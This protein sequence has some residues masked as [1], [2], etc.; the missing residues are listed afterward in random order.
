[1][2]AKLRR[3]FLTGATGHLGHRVVKLAREWDFIYCWHYKPPDKSIFGTPVHLNL[4]N[5]RDVHEALTHYK[6]DVI[7]HTACSNRSEES[8]VPAINNIAS[9]VANSSTRIVHVSTDMVLDGDNAP[10]SD[11]AKANPIHPYVKPKP[12]LRKLYYDTVLRPL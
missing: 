12:L 8:I 5:K 1:L 2:T 9:T 6:P 4:C 3:L 7:I 10:Y 11:N